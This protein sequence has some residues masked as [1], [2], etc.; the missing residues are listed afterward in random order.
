MENNN[1]LRIAFDRLSIFQLATALGIDI[2]NGAGQK[3]PFRKDR[4]AGSFSVQR[5]FFKDHADDSY[6]GGHIKFVSFARPGWTKK[7]CID[8]IIRESGQEPEQ[9]SA[10]RVHAEKKEKRKKLY[11]A[12]RKAAAEVPSLDIQEPPIW[13][14]PVRDRWL[15]GLQPL[16][17]IS[18]KL[19]RSR[20]WESRILHTLAALKKTSLP[21]LPWSDSAANRR[22]WGWAVERP[23]FKGSGV[24][25]V[26]VGFHAR[27][28]IYPRNAP[29][30][31]RWVYCPYIPSTTKS[32]SE[33]QQHLLKKPIK[34]PAYP[35]VLG[36]LSAPRLVVILEGQFD[37]VSFAAALQ[38]LEAFPPGVSVFGLRGVQSQKALLSVYGTWLKRWRPFVWIIGDNDVAGRKIDNYKPDNKIL[39][40]PTFVD[41]LLAYGCTVHAELINHPGCKD[42]NDVWRVAPPSI[43]IMKKWLKYVGVPTEVFQ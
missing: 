12:T 42:F 10:G 23:V 9:Q 14:D 22:G 11:E 37:A 8:F 38:W 34:L 13:S 41:H 36:N 32:F 17:N 43:D 1:Q 27:Y 35:F 3:N 30:E 5:S 19:A 25:L 20:G 6:K 33:F 24:E 15:G 21:L 2:R 28:K 29:V 40:Q 39:S 16:L 31:K 4:N 26:P 7:E 18:E